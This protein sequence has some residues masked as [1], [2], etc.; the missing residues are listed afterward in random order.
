MI[1]PEQ[2]TLEYLSREYQ[3]DRF[4]DSA[5]SAPEQK[6]RVVDPSDGKVWGFLVIDDTRRG[7]GLGGIRAAPDL[8]LNEVGRLARS[9]TLKNSAANIPFGGGKS[10]IVANPIFLRQNPSVKEKFIKSFAEAIFPEERYIPA[11]DMGTDEQDMQAI[12]DF[13]SEKL[14]RTDHM[15]GGSGRPPDRGGIPLDEWGLTAQGLYAAAE[16]LQ[17]LD[18]RF[19]IKGSRVVIQGY[20]NV[21]SPTADKLHQAGAMIVGASDIHV[22]LWNPDG[23]NIEKLN[24]I[25]REPGGLQDYT[26]AVKKKFDSNRL[27]WLLEA[28]CDILVPAARPDAITSRNVDRIQCKVILQGANTPVNKMTEYYLKNRKDIL[29]LSDFIVNVGGVIGCAVELKM[30]SDTP[31]KEKVFREGTRQYLDALIYE[32]I[33]RNVEEIFKRLKDS[34]NQDTIF[35]EEALR[36][37]EERLASNNPEIWL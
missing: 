37:A 24:R 33:S 27:D 15:R 7:P 29:S 16:T 3:K 26:G 35:R 1:L 4:S 31:Y 19:Q 8:S 28:P 6:I 36:L 22:A 18:G 10:G 20:G 14:N 9:M 21:G 17:K 23:L 12:F 5:L 32:T 30:A 25:R 34:K 2:L 13:Y 11:P